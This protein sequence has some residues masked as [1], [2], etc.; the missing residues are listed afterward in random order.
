MPKRELPVDCAPR[1]R[2]DKIRRLYKLDAQ[3]LLDETLILGR[4][5]GVNLIE[6]NRKQV[7]AFLDELTY[8]TESTPSVHATKAVWRAHRNEV[9]AR[10]VAGRTKLP[11]HPSTADLE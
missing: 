3:G 4:P 11:P 10:Q 6:G 8:G 1:V 9:K 7:L 5:T 2:Q